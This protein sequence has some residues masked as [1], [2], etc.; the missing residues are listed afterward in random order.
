MMI[1]RLKNLSRRRK[2][3]LVLAGLILVGA[4]WVYNW[5]FAGLPPIEQVQAG[6][7][8]PST[9]IFDRDGELLYEILPPEQGRNTVIALES[10]PQHCVNAAIATEDAN[11]YSHPGVDIVG[12]IRALWINIQGG[13]VIAGGSTITQQVARTLLLDPQQR[14]E[15]TLQRKLKE[16]LLALRLQSVYSKDDVLA[17]YL[18]QVYMGNL[19]YGIEGGARTYFG[20]SA[21]ELSLAE[22][23]LLVGIIQNPALHD[24]LTN[25]DSARY[26]QEVALDLMVQN[27]TITQA[28]AAIALSDDLQFASTRF[29]IEAPHFVMAVWRQLERNYPDALYTQG[30][31]VM[32]TVDADWQRAAQEIVGQQLNYLNHAPRDER[33]S[34]NANNAAVIALDPFT[35][36]VLTMLGSPDYFDES[37]DGAVN[38][39]LAMRQPGSA[40]KP[41]TYAAAMNPNRADPW[42]AATMV[43]D[44][45]TPFVTRKLE[46]YVPANYGFAEHGPVLIRE[47]LASSYNIPAVV[48]LEDVGIEAMVELAANAGLETLVGNTSYDL[49]VTLGGGEVR[50]MDMAQAYS[51]FPNG[52]YRVEPSMI[53]SVAVR[54]GE[55]LYTWEAP[56]LNRRVL[57]EQVAYLITDILSDPEARVPAFGRNNPLNIGRPAAAKTGTTTD[58]RDN[59]VLGYTPNLVV[60]VWVGNANNTPMVDVTGISGAGPIWNQFTRRVLLGQPELDFERPAGLDRVTICS[61]SGLLPTDTCA[62]TREEWFIPGTAPTETD[63]FYQIFEIDALTGGL[64]NDQTPPSRR[65]EAV[66]VVLPPEARD[67]ALAN[68]I[69]DPPDS[70]RRAAALNGSDVRLLSPDPYTIFQISPTAPLETQRIRFSAGVPSETESVTYLL[71]NQPVAHVDAHPWSVWW[72]LALGDYELTAVAQLHDGSEQHSGPLPFRVV[73]Y[74]EPGSRALPDPLGPPDTGFQPPASAP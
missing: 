54:G 3:L 11:F 4:L 18:N 39:A 43:L 42:T 20:K 72:T 33:P 14:A 23:A 57:D 44:V 70:T 30:L 45:S 24:P 37:I 63:T 26:R 25:L 74:E 73:E 17:M 35:G 48:A 58:F 56:N 34:A 13:E 31:D 1:S 16:M 22:C 32:T 59:W 64:A 19:A 60:G 50:L 9:R 66:Y 41:F 2:I 36:Q 15:R 7:A 67:W 51:I 46:S 38:A 52:G 12:V 10:I 8:L 68:G 62:H 40:L 6:F 29:P 69:P 55:T 61:L 53:L 21:T 47:A 5:L 28:E 49:S 65:V 27:D 71:N